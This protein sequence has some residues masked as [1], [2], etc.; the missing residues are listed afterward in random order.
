MT[1]VMIENARNPKLE[2]RQIG[3][4]QTWRYGERDVSRERERQRERER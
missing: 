3:V 2:A 1:A 4:L